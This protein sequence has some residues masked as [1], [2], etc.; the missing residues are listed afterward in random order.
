VSVIRLAAPLIAI[1]IGS[2][3]AD[4]NER[5]AALVN[6]FQVFC[7][8]ADPNFA[9]LDRKASAMKLP[10]VQDQG[11]RRADGPFVHAKTWVVGLNSG[12]H[13]LLGSEA[14]G[15]NGEI[16]G[17]G[18]ADNNASSEEFKKDLVKAMKLGAPQRES[19]TPDGKQVTIRQ[20]KDDTLL[21]AEGT[22]SKPPSVY[23]T[24][25]HKITAGH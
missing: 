9:V 21:L 13:A 6:S 24:L 10:V 8:L 17:C 2:F 16:T 25:I 12:P 22:S 14:R 18:I 19:A 7:T 20:F 4:A 5:T 11:E 1:I 3:A 23:I 15:P